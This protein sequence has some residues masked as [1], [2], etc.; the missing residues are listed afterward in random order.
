MRIR[1]AA[2]GKRIDEA[3]RRDG[4]GP[5]RPQS[6]PGVPMGFRGLQNA[7]CKAPAIS[8]SFG[9]VEN[10]RR[11]RA[12]TPT[13]QPVWRPALHPGVF[14]HM[15]GQNAHEGATEVVPFQNMNDYL[16]AGRH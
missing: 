1:P 12:W 16:C 4:I 6:H 3:M 9:T 11:A 14:I 8:G 10:R 7:G 15:G 13:L 2:K 5:L